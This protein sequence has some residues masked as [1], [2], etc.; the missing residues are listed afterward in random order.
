M[1]HKKIIQIQESVSKTVETE[2]VTAENKNQRKFFVKYPSGLTDLAGNI[3]K[4]HEIDRDDWM[5]S[6]PCSRCAEVLLLRV[7]EP[8]CISCKSKV[9]VNKS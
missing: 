9:G 7:D 3:G 8:I 4:W 1:K 6:M 5:V 2:T